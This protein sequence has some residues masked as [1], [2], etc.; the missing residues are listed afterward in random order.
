M[1][2]DYYPEG[3]QWA[4]IEPAD[5]GWDADGLKAAMDYLK[6]AS[7][8]AFLMLHRGRILA[9]AEWDPAD[10]GEISPGY[11]NLTVGHTDDHRVIEDITSIQKGV[12]SVLTGIA[13]GKKLLKLNAPVRNYLGKGWSNATSRKEKAITVHHL[14]SLTSGLSHELRFEAPPGERW[15]YNTPAY[16]LMIEILAE[17]SGLDRDTYTREW[18]LDPLQMHETRWVP[19]V[20]TGDRPL[21]N[22]QGLATTARDLARFGLMVQRGGQWNGQDIIGNKGWLADCLKSSS[23]ANPAY[24]LLW[25]LNGRPGISI[26]TGS[27]AEIR[28]SLIPNAPDDLYAALGALHRMLH[29]VPSFDLVLV[30]LGDFGSPEIARGLWTRL[31][32]AAPDQA[33]QNR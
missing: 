9:E 30:R 20:Q 10:A 8:S 7:S 24:G 12:V 33:L 17:V 1:S 26:G 29:I 16:A 19:R 5:A 2:R 31:K 4:R 25:W 6:S 27:Q 3:D 13:I 32:Q 23:D 22:K 28:S 18:L 15:F 11:A 21:V 14:M